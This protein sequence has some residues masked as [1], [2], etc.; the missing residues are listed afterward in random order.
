MTE[1]EYYHFDNDSLDGEIT[2]KLI[3]DGFYVNDNFE[4]LK[5]IEN[6][7]K[8]GIN[9]S[10]KRVIR[11]YTTTF[12]NAHCEYCFEN[13]IQMQRMDINTASAFIYY[14]ENE[15]IKTPDTSEI[16]ICWFGGEPLLNTEIISYLTPIILGVCD[17]YDCKCKFEMISNGSV[18][19]EQL[20][21]KSHLEWKISRVQITLD[22]YGKDYDDVKKYN[23]PA[24]YNFNRVI[25]NI[26]LLAK[27][28]ISVNI[29]L[30]YLGKNE[31]KICELI[32]Y[33]HKLYKDYKN[34][35]IY[36]SPVWNT[37]D[38]NDPNAYYSDAPNN[39]NIIKIYDKLL[40]LNYGTARGIAK[41]H[42]RMHQ[43][44]ACNKYAFS[45]LPNGDIVKCCEAMK[46]HIIGNV[47]E[48]I[49]D[50]K[51]YEF[52]TSVAIPEKCQKCVFLPLC[53]GG[54]RVGY[55]YSNMNSCFCEKNFFD[56]IIKW[57]LKNKHGI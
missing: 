10:R 46:D 48:G 27:N 51:E 12:C 37:G 49:T 56:D 40:S 17:K 21:I 36:V 29:R 16:V 9:D 50:T 33:L 44:M 35:S 38:S 55:C 1:D 30:N 53:Q 3:K 31:N 42:Y 57:Y 24:V 45:V 41:M 28:D 34:I 15:L 22:D 43:C 54:C 5:Q 47:N 14:L 8:D 4:E 39:S 25:N 23:N 52:W 26:T 7:R 6:D 18:F 13:G 2:K 32:D 19:D 20:I 11:I